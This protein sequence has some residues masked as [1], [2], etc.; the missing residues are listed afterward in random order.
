MCAICFLVKIDRR[1]SYTFK[2]R[3]N[4]FVHSTACVCACVRARPRLL[5]HDSRSTIKKCFLFW[6]LACAF[7]VK[8]NAL[9][10]Q[11]FIS[12]AGTEPEL[13]R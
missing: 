10:R 2:R 12:A 9:E 6:P 5:E 13:G 4:L 8:S 1:R 11:N 3:E 7:H